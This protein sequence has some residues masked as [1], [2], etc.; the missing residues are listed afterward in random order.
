MQQPGYAQ[1]HGHGVPPAQHHHQQ[2]GF[3]LKTAER[4]LGDFRSHQSSHKKKH[5]KSLLQQMFD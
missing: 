5:Q 1:P 2:Y 4:L 3:D